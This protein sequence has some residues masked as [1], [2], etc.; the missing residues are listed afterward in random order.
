MPSPLVQVAPRAPAFVELPCPRCGQVLSFTHDSALKRCRCP[1][2]Q[3][4]SNVVRDQVTGAIVA[5]AVPTA[6]PV[7]PV[8]APAP[9]AEGPRLRACPDCNREVSVRAA[10]CP[11]CGSPLTTAASKPSSFEA[12]F[13]AFVQAARQAGHTINSLDKQ[14]GRI[15]FNSPASLFSW[16]QEFTFVIIDN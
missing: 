3:A 13:S 6:V 15:V 11:H 7:T 8:P 4:V 5:L 10:Q 2:C 14:N 12:V 1:K 9:A 16:G